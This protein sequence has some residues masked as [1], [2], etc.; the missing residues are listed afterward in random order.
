MF[1]LNNK[2]YNDIKA[3]F[4]KIDNIKKVVLYGSRAIGNYYE[5]SDIDITLIGKDLTL[6][7][8]VYPLMDE[9]EELYLP[10]MFD[11]SIFN[12][13]DNE[14]LIEH[15]ERVGIVFYENYKYIND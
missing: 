10:Y 8:T 12:N 1:G 5:G 15:I 11:I 4:S 2:N 3:T 6:K 14:N 9:L 7:N 13:I